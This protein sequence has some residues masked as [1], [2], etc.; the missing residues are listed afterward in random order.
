VD[1][2]RLEIDFEK[3]GQKRVLDRFVEKA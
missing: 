1:Y 3:A 2:D